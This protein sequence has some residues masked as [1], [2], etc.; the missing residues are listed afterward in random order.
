MKNPVEKKKTK[1]YH[2]IFALIVK[3]LYTSIQWKYHYYL[4]LNEF[5]IYCARGICTKKQ[6]PWFKP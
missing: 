3:Q 2:Y 4:F 1:T 6:L 5:N